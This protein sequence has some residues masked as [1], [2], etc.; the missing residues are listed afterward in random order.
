MLLDGEIN[1]SSRK[2]P[3][4]TATW[5]TT[6]A[7]QIIVRY[8]L[9]DGGIVTAQP[10]PAVASGDALTIAGPIEAPADGTSPS[11][12][13]FEDLNGDGVVIGG[14]VNFTDGT[15]TLDQDADW[16]TPL[17]APVEVYSNVVAAS[18]GETVG[19]EVLGSGDASLPSQ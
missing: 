13:V 19:R 15:I 11:I 17:A 8:A 12:F 14:A 2:A 6:D 9:V 18:R 1:T 3:G 10:E 5:T 7:S 16:E 4:D